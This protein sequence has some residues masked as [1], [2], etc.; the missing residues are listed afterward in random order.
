MGTFLTKEVVAMRAAKEL[1]PSE[2]V[3][4]GTG[5]PS[6][7]PAYIPTEVEVLFHSE[8]GAIGF[9]RILGD[10][11]ADKIDYSYT[12]AGG[13]FTLPTP[14]MAFMDHCVSFIVITGGRLDL[15]VIGALEVSE[16]GDLANWT[17]DLEG[18]YGGI[19]GSMDLTTGAKRVLVLMTHVSKEGAPKIVRQ[20]RYPLTA[21]KRVSRI[22]TDA[23]VID[24]TGKGL[25]LREYAPGWTIGEIQEITEPRLLVA[26]DA[27]EMTL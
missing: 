8:I 21:R 6:L 7:V 14:G 17:T 4:I 15:S 11:D 16:Q 2:C 20:C 23:A 9:T 27:Q 13:Q 5:M 25:V 1:K 24:V 19:G 18:R 12:L 3:N 26:D 22:I 10:E